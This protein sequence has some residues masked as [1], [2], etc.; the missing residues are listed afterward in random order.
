MCHRLQTMPLI[1]P[2][3]CIPCLFNYNS[4]RFE[5]GVKLCIK[6]MLCCCCSFNW[7]AV[8]SQIFKDI[9]RFSNRSTEIAEHADNVCYTLTISV[10]AI[11]NCIINWKR[12]TK[13]IVSKCVCSQTIWGGFVCLHYKFHRKGQ[14]KSWTNFEVAVIFGGVFLM[15]Y[16]VLWIYLIVYI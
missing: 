15:T 3:L 14:P 1:D 12:G 11:K 5:Q 2:L 16:S 4:I 7:A 9:C 8:S 13:S 10:H 6:G